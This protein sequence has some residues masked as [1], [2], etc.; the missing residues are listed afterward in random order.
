M[1]FLFKKVDNSSLILFRIIFGLVLTVEAYGSIGTGWIKHT[2]IDPKIHFTFIGFEWLQPLPGNGM[3][4]YYAVMGTLGLGV[5]LGYRYKLSIT[6]YTV[7]WT[8]TYLMHK[9]S[10]NN[11][12]YL[13][14]L[15]CLIMCF[16]PAHKYKSVDVK[17]KRV[18]RKIFMPYWCRFILIFQITCVY[19]FGAIAK[20]YPD[21]LDG[22]FAALLFKTKINFPLLGQALF[23]KHWFHLFIS[24]GGFL[25]DLLIIPMLL[26]KKTRWF[27]F[28]A[29]VFF[30]SFN[31]IVFQVGVFPYLSISFAIFLFN[32]EKINRWFL[33]S[34]PYYYTDKKS[35]PYKP[36]TVQILLAYMFIQIA[37]PLRQHLFKDTPFWTEEAHKM[38]WRMMLRSKSGITTYIVKDLETQKK[39]KH[40]PYKNLSPKQQR[41]IGTQPDVIW[42]YAQYLK[43]EK[44]KEGKQVAVYA[45]TYMG[46]NGRKRQRLIDASVDLANTPWNYFGHKTWLTSFKGWDSK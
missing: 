43:K 35:Y 32:Q 33:K 14:V 19:I 15:L 6:L 26:W 40:S 20:V 44:L 38:S 9:A 1:K 39:E 18:Q 37:L 27:G 34:K 2:L 42:Q 21:W 28:F 11:H 29:S 8:A 23:Q 22:T 16:L 12:Y 46:L 30:H 45:E 24:Y 13:M 5:L 25:F 31:S 4:Y 10:Y 36:F 41:L 17:Q 7:M 3:Y